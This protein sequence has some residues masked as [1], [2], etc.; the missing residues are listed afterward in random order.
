MHIL[1]IYIFKWA[2]EYFTINYMISF[3]HFIQKSALP[4]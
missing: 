3:A 2:I 1:Y 4:F